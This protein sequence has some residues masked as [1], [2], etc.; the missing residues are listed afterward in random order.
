VVRLGRLDIVVANAGICVIK[1]WDQQTLQMFDDVLAVNVTGTWNTVM[2]AAPYLSRPA[3]GR[4][5]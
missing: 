4:S 5:S 1:P 3:A 2:A